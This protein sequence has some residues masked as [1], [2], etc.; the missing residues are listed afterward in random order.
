MFIHNKTFIWPAWGK[1]KAVRFLG[2]TLWSNFRGLGEQY[3]DEAKQDAK[4]WISIIEK[5]I[6]WDI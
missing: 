1:N 2:I 3:L 5:S 6:I 4:Q